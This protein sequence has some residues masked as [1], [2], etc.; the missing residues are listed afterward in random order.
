[1][2]FADGRPL[3][4]GKPEIDIANPS[5]GYKTSIAICRRYGFIQ[6][7]KVTDAASFDDACCATW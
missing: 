4:A 2:K 3:R 6:R 7:D 1:L 5:F